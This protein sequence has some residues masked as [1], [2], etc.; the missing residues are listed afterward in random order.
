M[1]VL[2]FA[3]F[4]RGKSWRVKKENPYRWI[5]LKIQFLPTLEENPWHW[6][7]VFKLNSIFC[8][9]P[10][11]SLARVWICLWDDKTAVYFPKHEFG[12]SNWG[13]SLICQDSMLILH[14]LICVHVGLDLRFKFR[15]YSFRL[16]NHSFFVKVAVITV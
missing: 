9:D 16:I 12:S 13:A 4:M 10:H 8:R 6:G 14:A 2:S 1:S 11:S 7:F 5:S 15:I 3:W